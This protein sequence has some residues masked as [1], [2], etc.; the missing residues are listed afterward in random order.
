MAGD[1]CFPALVWE[2]AL[3]RN[4]PQVIHPSL[5]WNFARIGLP[6]KGIDAHG[7]RRLPSGQVE[8]LLKKVFSR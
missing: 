4:H 2:G 1:K 5:A 6:I 8:T 7:D 3:A